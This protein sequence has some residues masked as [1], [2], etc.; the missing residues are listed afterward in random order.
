MASVGLTSVWG[1][2]HIPQLAAVGVLG[3]IELG[4]QR[5]HL[6]AVEAL[7]L[8]RSQRAAGRVEGHELRVRGELVAG[9]AVELLFVGVHVLRL[10]PRR[11][12]PET[13][14]HLVGKV[15]SLLGAGRVGGLEAV[16]R[17]RVTGEAPHVFQRGGIRLEVGAMAGSGR[18]ARPGLL[19]LA[20]L[21]ALLA[22]RSGH[23]GMGRHLVRPLHD[24]IEELLALRYDLE[25]VA[26]VAGEAVVLAL[27][28]VHHQVGP[29]IGPH[30]GL[31]AGH[32]DVAA[33]AEIVVVHHEVVRLE[34][35]AHHQQEHGPNDGDKGQLDPTLAVWSA[36]SRGPAVASTSRSEA[37]RPLSRPARDR[38]PSASPVSGRAI[39]LGGPADRAAAIRRRPNQ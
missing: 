27:H 20:L 1:L 15:T 29:G 21:V 33:L 28:L 13:D 11:H 16:G 3:G 23:L 35:T 9:V 32:E 19:G 2:W 26:G 24:P 22:D 39:G 25:G 36:R 34:A 10:E 17:A 38:R 31:S 4:E 8:A 7:P 12:S 18:D 6:V 37:R 30:E 14:L 5:P